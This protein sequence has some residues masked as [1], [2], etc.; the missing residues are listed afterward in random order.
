MDT[1]ATQTHHWPVW[2]HD[3]AVA[4]LRKSIGHA[5]VRHAYLFAGAESVGKTTLARAFAMTLNCTHPDE[6]VRPCG[7]CRSCRKTTSGNHPDLLLPHTDPSGSSSLKIEAVREIAGQIA[8][9]PFE[10]RYR[11]ALFDHFERAQPRAQD[12]LLK[13]LEEPPPHALLFLL[14]PS[15]EPILPTII[16]RSQVIHLRP[17]AVET[18]TALL[19][20]RG[21]DA[22]TAALLA[23]LSAGRPGWALRALAE[24]DMLARRSEALAVLEQLLAAN[25]IGRFKAAEDLSRDKAALISLLE[26]WQTYW[27]DL[28]LLTT[29]SGLTVSNL[30]RADQLEQLAERVSEEEALAALRATQQLLRLLNTNAN[31]RLALEVLMLD[32]PGLA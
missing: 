32:Y 1:Q 16:S 24:P 3:W 12:A 10:A 22:D 9:K 27:R 20:E 31:V 28:V 21:A 7:A 5:R 8:L 6:A 14:T 23:H 25:H 13:T 26:L 11:I 29:G 18:I 19:L 30:D 15:S 2:G 4:H 17:V